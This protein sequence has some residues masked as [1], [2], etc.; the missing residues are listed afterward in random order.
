MKMLTVRTSTIFQRCGDA[1]WRGLNHSAPSC[2]T[3]TLE[4]GARPHRQHLHLGSAYNAAPQSRAPFATPTPCI[5]YF[6][7]HPAC[8][9]H[10]FRVALAHRDTSKENA[11]HRFLYVVFKFH[12]L[13]AHTKLKSI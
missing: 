2:V 13:S 10:L 12:F 7:G 3:T 8:F 4:D 5:F 1:G 11:S 6:I 9:A